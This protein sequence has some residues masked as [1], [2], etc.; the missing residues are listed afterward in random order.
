M[1]TYSTSLHS[2]KWEFDELAFD[3][4]GFDELGVDELALSLAV[5]IHLFVFA[6]LSFAVLSSKEHQLFCKLNLNLT[7]NAILKI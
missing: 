1:R 2:T 5:I 4:L 7:L 3:E 6:D